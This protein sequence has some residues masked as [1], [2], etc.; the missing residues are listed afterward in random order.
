MLQFL[1]RELTL[2]GRARGLAACS[3]MLKTTAE[4][5]M[6]HIKHLNHLKNYVI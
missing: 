3:T 1:A 4:I 2:T 5:I 6:K